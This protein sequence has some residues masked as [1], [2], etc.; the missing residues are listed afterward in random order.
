MNS[1]EHGGH[2]EKSKYIL[3]VYFYIITM[4]IVLVL[5]HFNNLLKTLNYDGNFFA[6]IYSAMILMIFITSWNI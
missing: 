1:W 4:I 5:N 2:D 3:T 6:G